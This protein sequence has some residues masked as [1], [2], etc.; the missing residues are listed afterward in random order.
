MGAG[1]AAKTGGDQAGSRRD[2]CPQGA[3]G[4]PQRERVS[5]ERVKAQDERIKVKGRRRKDDRR[6]TME[7][8]RWTRNEGRKGRYVLLP[9]VLSKRSSIPHRSSA[10]GPTTT[11]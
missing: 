1:H 3:G 6:R 2:P 4:S 10:E 7:A 9:L 5:S 11:H 8:G